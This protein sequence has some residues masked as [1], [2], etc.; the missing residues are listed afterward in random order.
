MSGLSGLNDG[1][2][3]AGHWE[4]SVERDKGRM[5]RRWKKIIEADSTDGEMIQAEGVVKKRDMS[6]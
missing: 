1:G 5:W 4:K 3:C 6:R 2:G